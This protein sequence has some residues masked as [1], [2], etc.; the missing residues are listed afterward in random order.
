MRRRELIAGGIAACALSAAA[1]AQSA[2]DVKFILWV[3]TEAQPDPF[4]AGFSEGMRER[5]YVEGQNL[6][7]VLRYAPGDPAALYG[8]CCRSSSTRAPISSSRAD[9]RSSPCAPRPISPFCSP[10]A[11]TLSR[12]ASRKACRGQDEISPAAPSCRSMWRRSASSLSASSCP[13]FGRWR[14]LSQSNHP[15]EASE[16]EATK[17]AADALSLRLAYVPFAS[18]P[19]LD[20]ALGRVR[21]ANADAM[22][23]YPDGVTM[24]HRVKIAEFAK[25]LRLPSMFGWREYCEAGGLASYGANQRATYARLATYADRI[26]RGEKPAD[27]PIEQP[28][29][30]ELVI[31][32]KTARVINVAIPPTLLASADEV[33]E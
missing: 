18:G 12:W 16:H 11:A 21:A 30:F 4:I 32:M 14:S 24:V 6:A 28:T 17:Q 3:S 25:T 10:S 31:N 5:G 19:E 9:R 22:L 20:G 1:W 26:F 33:I 7:F 23:I 13:I 2:P 15:G 29:K 8:R 27:L